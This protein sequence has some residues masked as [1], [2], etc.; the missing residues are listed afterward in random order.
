MRFGIEAFFV[1]EGA[2]KEWEK[3]RQDGDLLAEIAVLPDGRAGLVDIRKDPA[4]RK[5]VS[6]RVLRG[7]QL[8]RSAWQGFVIDNA[9]AFERATSPIRP[10]ADKPDF[11][12]ER[13]VAKSHENAAQVATATDNGATVR[14]TLGTDGE[15]LEASEDLLIALPRGD[16]PVRIN[17]QLVEPGR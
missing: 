11:S 12:K 6:V 9:D 5:P 17:G 7:W 15:K 14:I 2:G 16:Q 3:L 10:D 4:P 1:P 8:E 13:V